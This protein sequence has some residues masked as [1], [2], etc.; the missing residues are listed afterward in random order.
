MVGSA[1]GRSMRALEQSLAAEVVAHE[2]EGDGQAGDRVDHRHD[3]GDGE[4]QLQRGDR[5]RLGHGG[6]ELGPAA[7]ER[8]RDERGQ[9]QQ[10][11]ERQVGDGERRAT[12]L[13]R[14]AADGA[15]RRG[16]RRC[17]PVCRRALSSTGTPTSATVAPVPLIGDYEL[18]VETPSDCSSLA[19]MPVCGS[20]NFVLT[21][22]QPPSLLMVKSVLGLGKLNLAAT[23]GR[24][25]R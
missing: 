19:T 25:G 16:G 7:A 4:R 15:Q 23:A 12:G 11:Q 22:V 21:R 9:R 13:P 14:H 6:P 2:H 5:L 18:A 24:T 20:K 10:H 17:V 3:G 8:V 1:K